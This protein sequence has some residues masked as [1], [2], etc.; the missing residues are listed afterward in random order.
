[1]RRALALAALTAAAVSM[2]AHSAASRRSKSGIV[3]ADLTWVAGDVQCAETKGA[4]RAVARGDRLHTGDSLRTGADGLARVEFPWMNVTLASGGV[5]SVPGTAVLST[6]LE[7]GRAE[8][9]GSGR[10]IVKILVGDGELRGGGRL[11]LW[12]AGG[13][14]SASALEGGFRVRA[15]ERVVEIKAGEGTVIVD[16][17]PPAAS[18]ALPLPPGRLRPGAETAY[19][20]SGQPVELQWSA[21]GRAHHVELLGLERDEVLLSRDASG[22]SLRLEVPWLGTYRWRVSTRDERG[23]ESRP[24]AAGLLCAVER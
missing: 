17:Q 11:V 16:G 14:T 24:S 19:V 10:D 20:R 18:S 15:A 1:M 9:F 4:W 5:L 13:R 23:L 3:V 7:Q 12:R 22:P 21:G 8:F 2:A 6:V